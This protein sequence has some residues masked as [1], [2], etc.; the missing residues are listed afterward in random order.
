[1]RIV[2]SSACLPPNCSHSS[3]PSGS[4]ALGGIWP[5]NEEIRDNWI[6]NKRRKMFVLWELRMPMLS[7]GRLLL[8]RCLC[9]SQTCPEILRNRHLK[10]TITNDKLQRFFVKVIVI[11]KPES[12]NLWKKQE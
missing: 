12:P 11:Y 5:S 7:P 3:S 10:L 6:I 8:E 1:M 4:S 9:Q 2:T